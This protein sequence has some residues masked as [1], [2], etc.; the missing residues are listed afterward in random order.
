[1]E[2]L[3]FFGI[4][5]LFSIIDSIARTRKKRRQ[6][7]LPQP[8]PDEPEW[9]DDVSAYDSV[10]SYEDID[11][12]AEHTQP[13]RSKAGRSSAGAQSS[14]GMIPADIWGEIAGLARGR[15]P[16]LDP[17]PPPPVAIEP[18]PARPV[19]THRV[20]LAHAHYGTDPS[21]RPKSE[22]DGLDPLAQKL[23][24]DASAVRRQLRSHSK[25]ALRRAV[26]LHEVLGPPAAEKA[27]RF[28][29]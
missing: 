19:Q 26:I 20:H 29:E 21:S 24:A 23:S 25:G 3:I 7:T 22:Q 5:I 9:E 14:E 17:A 2:E 27:D 13:Y 1:M 12:P 18:I 10:P 4:I 11:R 8:A 28:Q 6:G 16:E 15:L